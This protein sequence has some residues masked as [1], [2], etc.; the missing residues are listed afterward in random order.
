MKLAV[1][2]PFPKTRSV[3]ISE[4]L[5][6]WNAGR[7][8]AVSA[9]DGSPADNFCGAVPSRRTTEFLDLLPAPV[10][11]APPT[12]K[13]LEAQ[14]D[15]QREQQCLAQQLECCCAAGFFRPQPRTK[16]K[17]AEGGQ[18][19]RQRIEKQ[20][21]PEKQ[22]QPEARRL[23]MLYAEQQCDTRSCDDQTDQQRR[24][25]AQARYLDI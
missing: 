4:I 16:R 18:Y 22:Q 6:A 14:P 3:A 7:M 8:Q 12:R 2:S 11:R 10:P 19:V 24:Q 20:D 17:V 5:S 9:V 23:L 25:R 1:F 15:E 21:A 13:R